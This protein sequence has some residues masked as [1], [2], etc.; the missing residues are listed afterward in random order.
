MSERRIAAVHQLLAEVLR[1]R[2]GVLRP[3]RVLLV[4]RDVVGQERALGEEVARDGL[5]RDVHEAADAG[6]DRRLERVERRHQVVGEHPVRRVVRRVGDR[7]GVDDGVVAAHDR[8]G[9]AG[10]GQVGLL[11]RDPVAVGL[12]AR[13][14]E[15]GRADLVAGVGERRDGRGADLPA[16]ACDEDPHSSQSGAQDGSIRRSSLRQRRDPLAVLLGQLEVEDVEVLDAALVA[17]RLRHGGHLRLLDQPAQRDLPGAL[18]VR[19]ADLGERAVARDLAAGERG[20]GGQREVALGDEPQ[21]R[22]LREERV[23]LDLVREQRDELERLREHPGREVRDAGVADLLL[24]PQLVE[25]PHRVG[26]RDAGARPVEQQQVD[27][28]GPERAQRVLGGALEPRAARRPTARPSSSGRS[29]RGRRPRPRS[30]P[31]PRPRSRKPARCRC[32]GSR[33]PAR[34]ARLPRRRARRAATSRARS[35]GSRFP[36]PSGPCPSAGRTR[37]SRCYA[38]ASQGD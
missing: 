27:V 36:A 19:L 29:R 12:E 9:V 34:R 20:V 22:V 8:E 38:C 35:A 24:V 6:A 4:D 37:G 18:A 16:R 11:V 32:G 13:G 30:P 31:R 21:Q 7:G 5:A 2:V 17:R 25:R 10:V 33:S 23:V 3:D 26:E 14:A 28:V 15:V 1:G